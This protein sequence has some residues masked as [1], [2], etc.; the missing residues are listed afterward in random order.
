[1]G[2]GISSLGKKRRL[3]GRRP[4]LKRADESKG[5]AKPSILKKLG[6]LGNKGKSGRTG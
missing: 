4:L 3:L 5:T 1:M 2:K 6:F